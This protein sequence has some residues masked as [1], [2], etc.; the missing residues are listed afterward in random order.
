MASCKMKLCTSSLPSGFVWHRHKPSHACS[1]RLRASSLRMCSSPAAG[2]VVVE[3]QQS[4]SKL[5]YDGVSAGAN[6][7]CCAT[8]WPRRTCRVVTP[9]RRQV[10]CILL[11]SIY[12]I[13]LLAASPFNFVLMV[14]NLRFQTPRCAVLAL[15]THVSRCPPQLRQR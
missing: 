1:R 9:E 5:L 15:V 6:A 4:P 8:A 11:I 14:G 7:G 3:Q 13:M 2:T 12:V 10:R